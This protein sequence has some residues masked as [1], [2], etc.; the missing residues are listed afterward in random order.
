DCLFLNLDLIYFSCVMSR[1][2][3]TT[4]SSFKA[5]ASIAI[6]IGTLSISSGS[7]QGIEPDKIP[8]GTKIA[9]LRTATRQDQNR[10]M[11]EKAYQEG[12]SLEAEATAQSLGRAIEKYQ[13]ALRFYRD[14]GDRRQEAAALNRIGMAYYSLGEKQKAL[15]DYNQALPIKRD[16][17]DRPEEAA[18][19]S[20]IGLAYY[21]LG[22]R[23]KALDYYNQALPIIR[24]A[25]DRE[26]EAITLNRIGMAYDALGERQK[27]LD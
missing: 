23:Q 10:M 18:T 17:G 12:Q 21:S 20:D 25:D 9:E 2:M 22:E 26:G 5:Y 3:K 1:A 13:E 19:L 6:L 7:V 4:A 14:V 15:D 16:A 27:A 11:A 24:A 8:P